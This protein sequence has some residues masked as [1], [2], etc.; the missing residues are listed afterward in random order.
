MHDKTSTVHQTFTITCW[1]SMQQ[2]QSSYLRWFPVLILPLLTHWSY[3]PVELPSNLGSGDLPS[4][5]AKSGNEKSKN[6]DKSHKF[7]QGSYRQI[8]VKFKEFSR[9]S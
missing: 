3:I 9:T 2:N 5:Q 6:T 4:Q 8:C 7:L 1:T